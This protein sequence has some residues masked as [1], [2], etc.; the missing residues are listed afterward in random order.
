[1]EPTK[2]ESELYRH[3]DEKIDRARK[4]IENLMLSD[5]NLSHKMDNVITQQQLLKERVE[6]GVSKTVF[7]TFEAVQGIQ[8][9]FESMAGQNAIRDHKIG[10]VENM[11]EWFYRGL[12]MVFVAGLLLAVYKFK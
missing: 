10:R 4:D 11:V 2:P 9:Q 6:E 7:K 8:K 1:M 3:A 5:M 12:I